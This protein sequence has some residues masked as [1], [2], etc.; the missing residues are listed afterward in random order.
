MWTILKFDKKK[1]ES[2]KK[3]FSK[4]LGNDFVIYHP[5]SIFQ[6]YKNNMWV[7]KEIN[8]LGDYLFCFH[9]KFKHKETINSLKFSRGLKYFLDGFIQS[10]EE[11]QLFIKKCKKYENNKGYLSHEFFEMN[12]DSEYKFSSGPFANIIFKI[13]QPQKNKINILLGNIKT[14]I[15]KNDFLFNPL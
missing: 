7:N 12:I 5:K 8:F 1:F 6:K 4:K 9:K 13:I 2:L 3:D 15:K 11:I 10:Q 14:T